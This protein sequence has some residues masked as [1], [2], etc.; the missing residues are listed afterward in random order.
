M[1]Q[2]DRRAGRREAREEG[3]AAHLLHVNERLPLGRGGEL[4]RVAQVH[5]RRRLGRRPLVERVHLQVLRRRRGRAAARAAALAQHCMD[6]RARDERNVLAHGP[7]AVPEGHGR[8]CLGRH[9]LGRR[10]GRHAPRVPQLV[11]FGHHLALGR[12][13]GRLAARRHEHLR[14][15]G[16]GRGARAREHGRARDRTCGRGFM[17]RARGEGAPA[18]CEAAAFALAPFFFALA[19]GMAASAL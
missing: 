3:C 8:G 5:A 1:S 16:C 9:A 7:R 14:R 11:F 6:R 17:A 10:L 12:R 18:L 19:R 2:C 4:V 15:G 13:L